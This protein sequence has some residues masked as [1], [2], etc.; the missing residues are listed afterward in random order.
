MVEELTYLG[1]KVGGRGRDIFQK[2]K[3]DILQKANMKAA[4]LISEIKKSYDKTTVGKAVWKLQKM[5]TIL[6][7]KQVVTIPKHIIKKTTNHWKQSV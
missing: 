3:K 7:G 2:E 6:Y 4:Q 1:V 5:P